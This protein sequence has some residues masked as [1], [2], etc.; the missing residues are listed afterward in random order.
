MVVCRVVVYGGKLPDKK[1]CNY[2]WVLD[3]RSKHWLQLPCS[4]RC[5]LKQIL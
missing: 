5:I 4:K 3:W 1:S 2:V